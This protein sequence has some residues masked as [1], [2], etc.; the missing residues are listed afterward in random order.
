MTKKKKRHLHPSPSV[1]NTS[2]SKRSRQDAFLN[3]ERNNNT[4]INLM[5]T[6][7]DDKD[8][9]QARLDAS[10]LSSSR[11]ELPVYQYKHNILQAI[12]QNDVLL[13]MAET[14]SGKST[15]IPSYLMEDGRIFPKQQQQQQQQQPPS[16]PQHNR[17]HAQCIAVTQPRR[18]AAMTVAQRVAKEQGCIVGTTIGYR[19]RFDDCSHPKKTRVVYLTDGMLLREAMI[20]PL[21]SKYALVVLDE[22]HERSLQTDILFGVVKRAMKARATV[23]KT[24]TALV[25]H[26]ASNNNTTKNTAAAA[27]ATTS[28]EG[29]FSRD[30]RLQQLLREKSHHFRLPPLKVIVM[31]ATLDVSTFQTFFSNDSVATIQIP[32]RLFP[33]QHVYTSEPQEDYIDAALATALQIHFETTPPNDHDDNENGDHGDI[34]IFLPGQDEIEVLCQLLKRHLQ[35]HDQQNENNNDTTMPPPHNQL[36]QQRQPHYMRDIV[37]NVKGMGTTLTT[38]KGVASIINGVMICV[39]YAA[40]PPEAQLLAFQPKPK[41]CRRK[42]ILATNIAETSVTLDGI[43]YVIDTGKH[44]TRSYSTTTGMESLTVEPVSQAQAAQRSGRAGRVQAGI[45]F[46]LYTEEAFDSLQAV[47]VPEISRVNLAH[48]ILILKG[49]GI[50][51]PTQFEYLTRPNTRSIQRACQ[52]LYALKALSDELELTD[53]GKKMALL[54]VDPVYAHVILQSPNYGCTKEMLTVVA[55]LSAEN[56]LFRPG[57]GGG[58]IDIDQNSKSSSLAQKAAQA[59]RRFASYEGDLPTLLSIYNA[60]RREA[61]YSAG[62]GS[63]QYSGS[64]GSA[65]TT[66]KEGKVPHGQWCSHN[67]INGRALT[68]AYNVRQQLSGICSKSVDMGGLGIDVNTSCEEEDDSDQGRMDFLKCACAGLFLQS[69]T[70]LSTSAAAADKKGNSGRLNAVGTSSN[71]TRGRYK[72]KFGGQEASIHPTST[73]FGRNPAPKCVVYTEL[74]V[75]KKTY[76]RTVTQIREEWL[77]EV[78]PDFFQ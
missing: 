61:H 29:K 57:G 19:V 2:S 5:S 11:R 49:M 34:L 70:R 64:G 77:V 38:E 18:V 55:M 39:L 24:D 7:L 41:G 30:E 52:L 40:L 65:S 4:A 60:W 37:Q 13:V 26:T 43:R 46:R 78:A 47:T 48:V 25:Q 76:L 31:S 27:A 22:A 35:Q 72:T 68:R 59:H 17:Q 73:L 15:Q 12:H 53:H 71:S 1:A 9:K 28:S 44:K 3:S 56:V 16:R 10:D 45:C 50:H 66:A 8:A 51:D 20:D 63:K 42:I 6:E 14:G 33:V 58:G 32:G 62:V 75:T 54:P 21:L 67:F 36:Q 69:A 74:L 23:S